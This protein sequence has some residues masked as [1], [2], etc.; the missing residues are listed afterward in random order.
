MIGAAKLI[1]LVS[2]QVLTV[3]ILVFER[4]RIALIL[5][6]KLT[7]LPE[8]NRWSQY[9]YRDRNLRTQNGF[10]QTVV[11]LWEKYTPQAEPE[12]LLLAFCSLVYIGI[13]YKIDILQELQKRDTDQLAMKLAAVET[14]SM[15]YPE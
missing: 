10:M 2:M 11:P 3:N 6:E 9:K 14:V 8:N 1:P 7:L 15:V 13:D 5:C 4:E 12:K